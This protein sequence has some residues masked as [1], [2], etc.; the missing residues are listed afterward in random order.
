MT[1]PD[2][3]DGVA[4]LG[5]NEGRGVPQKAKISVR[6]VPGG[7]VVV[8]NNGGR[9]VRR[10]TLTMYLQNEAALQAMQAKLGATGNL[11][12]VEGTVS[13]VLEEL[14]AGEIWAG[15]V[16]KTRATFIEVGALA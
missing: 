9:G 2:T 12:F 13:A 15:G 14:D 11:V 4:F 3:F 5:S 8:L 10:R 16:L 7:N 6:E 1:F